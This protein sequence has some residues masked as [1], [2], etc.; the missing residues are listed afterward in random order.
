MNNKQQR[1][2]IN[3]IVTDWVPVTAGVPQ[4]SILGAAVYVINVSDISIGLNSFIIKFDDDTKISNS[5]LSDHVR[6]SLQE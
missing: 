6:Q 3:E 1:V 5:V 2:V 4:D